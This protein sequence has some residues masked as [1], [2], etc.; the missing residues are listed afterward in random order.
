MTKLSQA[1]RHRA[2]YD[3]AATSV[4][5]ISLMN[6]GYAP[7]NPVVEG[8]ADSEY[9]CLEL[10]RHVARPEIAG[11]RVLEVSC[12]RGGGA[13]F[14]KGA[15]EPAAYIG[16]DLSEEN[17]R[18]A[19]DRFGDTEGLEFRI[20]SADNLPFDD[21]SFDAV[22]NVEASH[23]YPDMSRFLGE[24]ARVLRPGGL[25]LY[26]DLF[27]PDSAPE[28]MMADAGL[29]VRERHDVTANVLRALDLD[30]A[31]R[32]ALLDPEAPEDKRREF[33]DWAG[34]KGYRAY[35]RLVSGEWNYRSFVALRPETGS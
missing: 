31:R 13:F 8:R 20:G 28:S 1:E 33:R 2:F 27:W 17:V 9:L 14:V 4:A 21:E 34:V 6:Y 18:I 22:L 26:T 3:A 35:N 23:L 10:Y 19:T 11:G 16:V 29:V 15:F 12:G 7:D 32:D 5:D 24:V 25:F 30:S